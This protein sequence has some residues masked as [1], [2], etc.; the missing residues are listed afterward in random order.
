MRSILIRISL[1]VCTAFAAA[2]F[3][4][5]GGI[6]LAQN[7]IMEVIRRDWERKQQ[8]TVRP[9]TKAVRLPVKTRRAPSPG[10]PSRPPS[11]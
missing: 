3:L 8:Q 10:Q 9:T 11:S 6:A 1:L 5:G 7:D 2:L 4:D